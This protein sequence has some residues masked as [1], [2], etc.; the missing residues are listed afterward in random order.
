M[1]KNILYYIK[2]GLISVH[3]H[4]HY[5]ALS[6]KDF[7][8]RDRD[9]SISFKTNSIMSRFGLPKQIDVLRP[10]VLSVALT[11]LSD[12]LYTII[13]YLIKFIQYYFQL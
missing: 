10:L 3:F 7:T 13:Y 5:I 12:T 1:L 4:F 9:Q 11:I 8:P 2:F 6:I